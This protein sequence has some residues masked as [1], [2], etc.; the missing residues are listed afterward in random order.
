MGSLSSKVGN[1]GLLGAHVN[2]PTHLIRIEKCS[3]LN[4]RPPLRLCGPQE[5]DISF[6][7]LSTSFGLLSS[8]HPRLL[9]SISQVNIPFPAFLL[10][11]NIFRSDCDKG[12]VQPADNVNRRERKKTRSSSNS[13]SIRQLRSPHERIRCAEA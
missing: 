5:R 9:R 12:S 2:R 1:L 8:S 4:P 10:R 6:R 7:L 13:S 3:G 11:A